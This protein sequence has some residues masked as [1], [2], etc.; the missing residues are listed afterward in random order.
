MEEY[1]KYRPYQV[2]GHEKYQIGRFTIIKDQIKIDNVEYPY[3]YTASDDCVV[4]FPMIEDRVVMIH[5]YRH[6]RNE[7]YWEIPAGGLSGDTPEEAARRELLEETGYRAKKMELIAKYPIS[8]G[9]SP[10]D[11]WFFVAECK[12]YGEQNLDKTEF[13]DEVKEFSIEEFESMIEDHQYVQRE[14]IHI[15]LMIK[16]RV[17]KGMEG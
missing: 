17:Q 9:T 8:L 10:S 16:D 11:T 3:S 1:E 13:I 15:W 6:A 12:P 4:V 2:V 5:Q 14:G 7:W